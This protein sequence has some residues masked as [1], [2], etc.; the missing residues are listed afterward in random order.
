MSQRRERAMK[1]RGRLVENPSVTSERRRTVVM[2][3]AIVLLVLGV[4]MAFGVFS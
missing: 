2:V 1:R 3:V 4:L